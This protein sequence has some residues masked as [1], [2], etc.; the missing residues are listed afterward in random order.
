MQIR[1]L[2][3]FNDNALF[4][5]ELLSKADFYPYYSQTCTVHCSDVAFWRDTF[6]KERVQLVLQIER[7]TAEVRRLQD[8]VERKTE[9]NIRQQN[10]IKTLDK[11]LLDA[12]HEIGQLRDTIKTE[13]EAKDHLSQRFTGNGYQFNGKLW[14]DYI[15]RLPMSDS[16]FCGFEK[17]PDLLQ[18]PQ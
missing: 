9:D 3:Q 2:I 5:L 13:V 15:E 17:C 6:D 16:V 7:L 8:D 10:D 1:R 11:N 4:I 14:K 12:G 18:A